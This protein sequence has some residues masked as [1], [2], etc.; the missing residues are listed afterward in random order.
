MSLSSR[1]YFRHSAAEANPM[2]MAAGRNLSTLPMASRP[3]NKAEW[4]RGWPR[5]AEFDETVIPRPN[6]NSK[7]FG[8]AFVVGVIKNEFSFFQDGISYKQLTVSFEREAS[9][10]QSLLM[11]VGALIL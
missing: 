10:V 2:L 6:P 4:S 5:R 11:F 8:S 7:P 3:E 1:A 9:R